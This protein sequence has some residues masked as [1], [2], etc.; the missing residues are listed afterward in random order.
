MGHCYVV[1]DTI[2]I[3]FYGSLV[4]YSALQL[5]ITLGTILYIPIIGT[6]YML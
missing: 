6:L 2:V 3:F 4:E 5:Y 1:W